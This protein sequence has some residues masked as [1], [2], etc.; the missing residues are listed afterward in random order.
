MSSTSFLRALL[1]LVLAVLCPLLCS[2]QP[3]AETTTPQA[4]L[5]LDATTTQALER[6]AGLLQTRREQLRQALEKPD[7]KTAAS[8]EAEIK[9]LSWQFAGLTSRMDVQEFEAPQRRQFD[10][11]QEFEELIR[12]LLQTIKDATEEPRQVADLKARIGVLEQRLRI[13][14]DAMNNDPT[15]EPTEWNPDEDDERTW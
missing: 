12:P 6:L 4:P 2:Q 14:Q 15:W 3:G 9:D 8:L 5:T 1:P 11:N 7:L 13:V 10:V